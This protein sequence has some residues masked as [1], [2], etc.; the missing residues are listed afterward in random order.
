MEWWAGGGARLKLYQ[1]VKAVRASVVDVRKTRAIL[2]AE[3]IN[4]L[5]C[6]CVHYR[7]KLA[8]YCSG[9]QPWEMRQ[10]QESVQVLK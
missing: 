1:R 6:C 5:E 2:N 7:E 3:G 4:H 10:R 8:G 9:R